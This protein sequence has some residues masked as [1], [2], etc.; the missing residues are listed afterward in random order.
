MPMLETS[1]EYK[2][3]IAGGRSGGPIY[4]N[5]IARVLIGPSAYSFSV[6]TREGFVVK[7]MVPALFGIASLTIGALN[8][9]Q[10]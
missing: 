2:I 6:V 9:L 7:L 4:A 10:N 8:L 3:V 5:D 1:G